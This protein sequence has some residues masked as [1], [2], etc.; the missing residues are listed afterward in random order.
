MTQWKCYTW[1]LITHI[2][3]INIMC[4]NRKINL[5]FL[6]YHDRLSWNKINFHR[7]ILHHLVFR[8]NKNKNTHFN[9][10]FFFFFFVLNPQPRFYVQMG[11]K[12]K[13]KKIRVCYNNCRSNGCCCFLTV[14]KC[15][16]TWRKVKLNI[17]WTIISM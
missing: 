1:H 15:T 12:S 2:P 17:L 11:P 10:F 7:K 16:N 4:L 3:I 5:Q 8:L 13:W 9:I 6:Y 14:S